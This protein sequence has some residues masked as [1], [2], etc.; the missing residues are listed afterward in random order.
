M[1]LLSYYNMTAFLCIRCYWGTT[2]WKITF[3]FFM[4]FSH[5]ILNVFSNLLTSL[6][7]VLYTSSH[8]TVSNTI[9]DLC[10]SQNR[11]YQLLIFHKLIT[12]LIEC[13]YFALKEIIEWV[14]VNLEYNYCGW[15]YNLEM[16][17]LVSIDVCVV[18]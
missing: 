7:F 10:I 13:T 11:I 4:Y 5:N 2:K 1:I 14:G 12:H 6:I 16:N 15:R 3:Y 17:D 18:I 9:T 8:D